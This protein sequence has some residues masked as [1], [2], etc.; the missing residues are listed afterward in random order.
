MAK[1]SAPRKRVRREIVDETSIER[2]MELN[3]KRPKITMR[4]L[5]NINAKHQEMLRYIQDEKTNMV[6]VNG[7]AGTAKTY[8]GVYGAL[9]L[10]KTEK[11]DEII[12]IRSII[13]SA[14]KSMGALPGELD[15]KF[16][17]YTMPLIDKLSEILPSQ[18][19]QPLFEAQMIRTVPVNFT[20]GLTFNRACVIIDEAQNLT[21]K[22]LVTILTRFGNKSTYIV[23]GDTFQNDIKD[24]GF[25]DIMTKFDTPKSK[26]H[27]IFCCNF[28]KTD[29]V[30]S[31]ILKYIVSVLEDHSQ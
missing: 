2:A 17:P 24:T 21:K 4:G 28:D 15:D 8:V 22:E 5:L 25:G 19:I 26:T 18:E 30:R 27:K 29:I 7:P 10:L 31:A 14:S 3:Y 12:Y 13:E 20:R 9:E 6:F 1:K 23:C 11:V 16:Q